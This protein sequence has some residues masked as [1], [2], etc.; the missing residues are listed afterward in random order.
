MTNSWCKNIWQTQKKFYTQKWAFSVDK[1]TLRYS[2]KCWDRTHESNQRRE[3][4]LN[5]LSSTACFVRI[6][7]LKRHHWDVIKDHCHIIGK[8]CGAAQ[9]TCSSKL[10]INSKT[11]PIPV[12]I[13][14]FMGYYT[15]YM[16]N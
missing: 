13:H 4:E 11:D 5:Q 7:C 3:M 16:S 14:D 6:L 1:A 2:N 8:F 9:S 12:V 10:R 15:Q